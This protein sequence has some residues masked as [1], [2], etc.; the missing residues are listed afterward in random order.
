[1]R[2]ILLMA[3]VVLAAGCAACPDAGSGEASTEPRVLLDAASPAGWRV[4][5]EG[6]F[7]NHGEVRFAGGVVRLAPGRP[8]TGL[9]WAEEFPDSGYEVE[10]QVRRTAGSDFFCGMTFPV[11]PAHC[12]WIVGG[13]GGAV[14]GLSNVDGR[15][16]A[17]NGTT[18][19]MTF[20]TGRWYGLRLRVT[21]EAIACFI[22]GEQVIAQPRA[23]HTFG[24]WPQ[25]EPCRPFGIAAYLTGSAVRSVTLRHVGE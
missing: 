12:T 8:L 3:A 18:R 16:A 9:A 1:M 2:S 24:I 13:W 25:Q 15:S 23:G 6:A 11:G 14:V 5:D 19:R 21:D 22:D 4:P 10:A 7:R 17:E 20:E